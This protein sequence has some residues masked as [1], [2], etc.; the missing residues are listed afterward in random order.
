MK[1]A[2]ILAPRDFRDETLSQLKLY[3]SKKDVETKLASTT[4]GKCFGAH[5]AVAKSELEIDAMNPL[6]FDAVVVADG[7]GV[8]SLK[9]F[10]HRPLLDLIKLF[11]EANKAVVGIGN[12]IKVVARANII[13]DMK[14]AEADAETKKLVE[15][16]RGKPTEEHVVR[17]GGI[18]TASS[19]DDIPELVSAMLS[20]P[21]E[22]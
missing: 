1:V 22:A 6:D 9:M 7:P 16:Y 12:G 19:N 21:E 17:D 3:F 2:V 20:D 5:G 11:K 4:L 8:D 13:K 10:D 18:I 14:I 15:L